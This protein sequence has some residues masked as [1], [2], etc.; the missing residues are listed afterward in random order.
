MQAGISEWFPQLRQGIDPQLY[1]DHLRYAFTRPDA[2]TS[3]FQ[4]AG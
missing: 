1:H 4:G 2:Y 3:M